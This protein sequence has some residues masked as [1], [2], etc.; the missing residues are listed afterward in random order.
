[1]EA[2]GCV[3]IL[4]EA[5]DSGLLMFQSLCRMIGKEGA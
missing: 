4:D 1:M 2:R 5:Q 3:Y